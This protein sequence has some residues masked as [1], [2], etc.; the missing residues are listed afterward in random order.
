MKIYYFPEGDCMICA[1][2]LGS[3]KV[4]F[5]KIVE[6]EI[7]RLKF[8]ITLIHGKNQVA[9]RKKLTDLLDKYENSQVIHLSDDLDGVKFREAC[10]A[11][12]LFASKTL[13]V[14]E[15]DKVKELDFFDDKLFSYLE[16]LSQDT[17]VIFWVGEKVAKNRKIYKELAELGKV[18][19]FEEVEDKPFDF[20]DALAAKK[21]K[22]AYLELGILLEQRGSEIGLT[23]LIAWELR[24]LIRVKNSE[25]NH[26][27][28]PFLYKKA[29]RF[30]QNFSMG[31]LRELFGEVLQ[32]DLEMKTGKDPRLVLDTLIYQ[33]T[34]G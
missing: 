27:L 26:G 34:E 9:S 23:Q 25:D 15:V 16:T 12:A 24:T 5:F 8:M 3:L 1:R 17:N 30:A 18:F 20:L 4:T 22:Q 21:E 31:E 11:R 33:I 28:H 7:S 6:I 32:A 14:V 29:K 13:V 19:F 2:A 10:E